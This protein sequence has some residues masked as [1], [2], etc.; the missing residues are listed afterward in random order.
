MRSTSRAVLAVSALVLGVLFAG[1]A[2]GAPPHSTPQPVFATGFESGDPAVERT[3]YPLADVSAYWGTSGAVFRSG[4]RSLWCA[5]TDASTDET[6]TF[7]PTYPALTMGLANVRLPELAD[8]FSSSVSFWYLME[9]IGEEDRLNVSVGGMDSNGQ[10]IIPSHIQGDP[11]DVSVG[12]AKREY[13]LGTGPTSAASRQP[14]IVNVAFVDGLEGP[15]PG[16]RGQGPAIDDFVVAGYRYGS[17]RN[18]TAVWSPGDGGVAVSWQPPQ[19]SATSSAD[20]SR[21]V[22]YRV[23]RSLSGSDQWTELNPGAPIA[24]TSLIDGGAVAARIYDYVVQVWSPDGI[25]WHGVQALPVKVTTP[26]APTPPIAAADAYDISQDTVLAISA[27]GVLGNDASQAPMAAV[28]GTDP[29]H[30]TLALATDGSFV[31]TPAAE[32]SGSDAF[33][34]RAVS[35]SVYSEP[36]TVTVTVRPVS[37]PP[38]VVPPPPVVQPAQSAIVLTSASGTL[39]KYGAPFAMQGRLESGGGPLGGRRVALQTASAATGPFADTA[40]GADTAADGSFTLRDVPR[41]KTFYRVR[42]AGQAGVFLDATS[43][44]RAAT[45]RAYVRTPIAPRTMRA[46]RASAVYGYLKPRHVSG[47]YPVRIYRYRHVGGKWK[48]YG[49]VKAKASAYSSYTKYSAKVKLPSRGRWRL[50]AYH[51]ADSGHAASWSSGFDYVTVR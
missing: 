33:S 3:A 5:G 25:T 51:P 43:A 10:P 27:P 31:Y 15:S 49:Y 35:Q 4:T 11:V 22:V 29:S 39:A 38:V 1:A 34:Y 32:W 44:V 42:F 8:F 24:G 14:L 36:A 41:S 2:Y 46:G 13:L 50:R 30:G 47:S 23:W 6:S 48:S 19:Q 7:W 37:Q 12:W 26:G 17:V 28:V 20:D 45:P 18:L 9:S 16:I 21:P 40:I